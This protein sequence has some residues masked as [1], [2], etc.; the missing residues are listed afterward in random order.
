[1]KYTAPAINSK[2]RALS[3]IRGEKG[4]RGLDS[5]IPSNMHTGAPAYE[6]DE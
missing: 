5:T 1:M 4:E 3:A 2:T 6:A